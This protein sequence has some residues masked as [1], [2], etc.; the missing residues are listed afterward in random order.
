MSVFGG[1]PKVRVPFRHRILVAFVRNCSGSSAILHDLR[2]MSAN[3]FGLLLGAVGLAAQL[4]A[5][6]VILLSVGVATQLWGD[7]RRY[8][9]RFKNAVLRLWPWSEPKGRQ[10]RVN[11]ADTITAEDYV[12]RSVER[13]TDRP[14]PTSFEE[15]GERLNELQDGW[16]HHE[17]QLVTR[18]ARARGEVDQ[19]KTESERRHEEIQATFRKEA[20]ERLAERRREGL[21]LVVG[22]ALQLAGA[23][24]L[25][26]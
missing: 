9:R 17:K 5:I 14:A 20:T 13:S 7:V 8:A 19:I 24:V 21:L 22:V 1:I 16:N 26:A 6:V 10:L 12:D 4:V 25:L 3:D 2:P 18:S 11:L 15:V 23:L